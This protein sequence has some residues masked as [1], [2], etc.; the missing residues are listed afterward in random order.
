M[1]AF[2]LVDRDKKATEVGRPTGWSIGDRR[3]KSLFISQIND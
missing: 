2:K 1:D 3:E